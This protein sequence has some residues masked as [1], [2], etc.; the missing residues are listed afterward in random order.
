MTTFKMGLFALSTFKLP[1][2]FQR[3]EWQPG[4]A[5]CDL[6]W[7]FVAINVAHGEENQNQSDPP[8]PSL[9]AVLSQI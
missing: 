4:T 2:P 9:K 6:P 7:A 1:T 5:H 8:P 3:G